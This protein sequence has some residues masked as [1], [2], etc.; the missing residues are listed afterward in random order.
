MKEMMLDELEE[1]LKS[2]I[3]SFMVWWGKENKKAP[4]IFPLEMRFPDW[5]DQFIVFMN[6]GN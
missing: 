4:K 5:M 2:E 1:R 6:R 3:E